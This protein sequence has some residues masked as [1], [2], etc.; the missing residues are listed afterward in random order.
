MH[1]LRA[2][3]AGGHP[4]TAEQEGLTTIGR[5]CYICGR[6]APIGIQVSCFYTADGERHSR[7]HDEWRWYCK[8]H[9]ELAVMLDRSLE[10]T[11]RA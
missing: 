10:G 9:S 6:E 7:W 3:V 8:R 2:F 1:A 5:A 4:M 11:E